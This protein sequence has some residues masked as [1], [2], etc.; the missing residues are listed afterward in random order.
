MNPLESAQEELAKLLHE[1]AALDKKIDAVKKAIHIFG[2]VYARRPRS[3]KNETLARVV[4]DIENL[5]I[6][7]AIERVLMEH[8]DVPMGPKN[9]RNELHE[10]N[11]KL[12]GS[13][14]MAA[15]HQVLKRLAARGG[16]IV[17]E[18]IPG[19]KYTKYR[20]DPSRPSKA[21]TT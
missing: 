14:P 9:V 20:Y 1:R 21:R 7:G 12:T 4:E 5:G 13:N 17:A 11:F 18:K 15:I 2:P 16:P 10:I 19:M 6:T 3:G 8:P